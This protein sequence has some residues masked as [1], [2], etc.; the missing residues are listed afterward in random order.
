MDVVCV[1][2]V[3]VCCVRRFV[4]GVLFVH[5]SVNLNRICVCSVLWV[6]VCWCDLQSNRVCVFGL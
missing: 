5:C 6:F 4:C 1:V 2:C 3:C